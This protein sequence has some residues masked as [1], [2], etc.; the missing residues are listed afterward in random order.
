LRLGRRLLLLA[1]ARLQHQQLRDDAGRPER[2]FDHEPVARQLGVPCEGRRR[3]LP[4]RL[5]SVRLGANAAG[6]V[7]ALGFAHFLGAGL[8]TEAP[9]RGASVIPTEGEEARR[10]PHRLPSSLPSAQ[11]AQAGAHRSFRQD[12]ARRRR[13][14]STAPATARS[15]SAALL[16]GEPACHE[17]PPPPSV[18]PPSVPRPP[19]A[20]AP[21]E[22]PGRPPPEP[23]APP[24]A[25]GAPPEPDALPPTPSAPPELSPA[26]PAP[27]P[28]V[29]GAPPEP[30]SGGVMPVNFHQLNSKRSSPLPLKTKNRSSGPSP[31]LTSHVFVVH[32]SAPDTSQVPSKVPDWLPKCSSMAAPLPEPETR[33]SKASTPS[34][35]ST[36]FTMM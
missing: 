18:G 9:K 35:K 17:Q 11:C 34:L 4:L 25:T 28:P 32:V 14:N 23:S 30:V 7:A 22:A 19:E 27:A 6:A 20:D 21:P 36:F 13:A 24:D 5:A 15:A 33:A 31:P 8:Q 16:F 3:L 10:P 12:A 2:R 29:P 1:V 26:P